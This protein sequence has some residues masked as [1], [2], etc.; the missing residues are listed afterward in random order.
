M[1]DFGFK[2]NVEKTFISPDS[3]TFCERMYRGTGKVLKIVP[4]I[5]LRFCNPEDEV[6]VIK[7]LG[8]Q[9]SESGLRTAVL[10]RAVSVGRPDLFLL[11]KRAGVPLYIPSFYGGL[12]LPPKGDNRL[13]SKKESSKVRYADTH[14]ISM[15]VQVSMAGPRTNEAAKVLNKLKWSVS[16]S[17]PC[18]HIEELSMKALLPAQMI[19]V[20]YGD[21][22]EISLSPWRYCKELHKRFEAIGW[23]NARPRPYVSMYSRDI[24]VSAESVYNALGHKCL[25]EDEPVERAPVYRTA[26]LWR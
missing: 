10:H 4:S 7:D 6:A 26:F 5:S 9:L 21:A 3:G 8:R 11:G 25:K 13:S 16:V 2:I 19:D 20:A 12:G 24:Q 17:H 14:G 22:K 23:A 18:E 1:T 15:P